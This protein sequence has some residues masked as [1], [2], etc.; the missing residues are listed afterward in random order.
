[1]RVSSEGET[2][3][4]IVGGVLLG[5]WLLRR[6]DSV[7]RGFGDPKLHY[8]LGGDLYGFASGWVTSH[9]RLTIDTDQSPYAGQNEYPILLDLADGRFRQGG[10]QALRNFLGNFALFCQC[11]NDLRL[12]HLFSLSAY[13]DEIMIP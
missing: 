12:R 4:L 5:F 11:L 13:A 7:F 3:T 1:M 6:Y 10:K 8:L 2:R 9:P